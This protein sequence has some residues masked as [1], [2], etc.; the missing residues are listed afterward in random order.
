VKLYSNGD[1]EY[2]DG[3]MHYSGN[4]DRDAIPT[5]SNYHFIFDGADDMDELDSNNAMDDY[6]HEMDDLFDINDEV[7]SEPHDFNLEGFG[8]PPQPVGSEDADHISSLNGAP[9][10]RMQPE[11]AENPGHTQEY[12]DRM[13]SGAEPSVS[14]AQREADR[15]AADMDTQSQDEAYAH[16]MR[17]HGLN[18]I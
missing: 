16:F 8:G 2:D 12:W 15:A 7:D 14:A 10:T 5:E 18:T 11:G 17:D 3:N 1:W 9:D 13:N 4:D 6:D